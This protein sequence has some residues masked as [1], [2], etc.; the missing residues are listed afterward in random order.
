MK[1]R[2]SNQ[3]PLFVHMRNRSALRAVLVF[4]AAAA[5]ASIVLAAQ[6][7]TPTFRAGVDVIAVDVQVVDGNGQP[8]DQLPVGKFSVTIDG[9]D[10][11][12]VSVDQ[13]RYSADAEGAAPMPAIVAGPSARNDWP[14]GG[15][16]NRMFLLAFDVGSFSL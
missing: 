5:A 8:I 3:P 1:G 11:R 9:H 7:Q 6:S 16:V 12:I 15:P 4:G 14:G 2:L 10:R 13:V